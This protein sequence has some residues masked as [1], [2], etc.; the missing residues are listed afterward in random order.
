MPCH[1]VH[2]KPSAREPKLLSREPVHS[3]DFDVI[4]TMK[5]LWVSWWQ[6]YKSGHCST[7][8]KPTTRA[9]FSSPLYSPH[10]PGKLLL[11]SMPQFPSVKWWCELLIAWNFMALLWLS[12]DIK[13]KTHFLVPKYDFSTTK[14]SARLSWLPRL[15]MWHLHPLEPRRAVSLEP[16]G[17]A[18]CGGGGSSLMQPSC[19]LGSLGGGRQGFYYKSLGTVIPSSTPFSFALRLYFTQFI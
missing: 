5:G 19:V 17:P 16:P 3:K 12:N 11:L 14:N 10:D 13:G 6:R 4:V 15:L 18:F 8:S 2:V 9:K 1:R 7:N